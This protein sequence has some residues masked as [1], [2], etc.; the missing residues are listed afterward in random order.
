LIQPA[1]EKFDFD[2]F[3]MLRDLLNKVKAVL[4]HSSNSSFGISSPEIPDKYRV[5]YDIQQV[6]RNAMAWAD[7]KPGE[8]PK[9]MIVDYDSPMR[10]GEE[11]FCR[12]EVRKK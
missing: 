6:L 9:R 5:A 12:C 2:K 11:P 1:S 8:K 10:T 3:N 7:L 4:G